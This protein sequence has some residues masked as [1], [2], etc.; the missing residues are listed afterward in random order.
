MLNTSTS[1]VYSSTCT[2]ISRLLSSVELGKVVSPAGATGADQNKKNLSAFCSDMLDEYLENEG[3]LI[4]ERAAS[5]SQP[6]LEALVYELPARSS[7]YVRTLNNVLNRQTASAPASDL[8][9]GFVPPSRRPKLQKMSR[10]GDRKPK[11]PKQN[12]PRPEPAAAAGPGPAESSPVVPTLMVNST[13][14]LL[15]PV[16]EPPQ[17]LDPDRRKCLHRKTSSQTLSDACPATDMAP[18]D[19]DSERDNGDTFSTGRR[20]VM[21]RELLKQ[22]DLEDGVMW[23]GRPRTCITEERAS[24]ALTSL[25]TLKVTDDVIVQTSTWSLRPPS[26]ICSIL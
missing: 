1:V 22:R 17:P 5:F 19:S 8:I 14:E 13:S 12:K 18:L 10:K 15:V 7:S 26:G 3:K 21:T 2:L 23:E 6:P 24:I 25:F 9:S 4:D 16:T 11:S 20:P